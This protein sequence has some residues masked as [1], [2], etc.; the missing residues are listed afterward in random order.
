MC[1]K[2][3]RRRHRA[4]LLEPKRGQPRRL[5][6]SRQIGFADSQVAGY[7]VSQ[8]KGQFKLDGPAFGSRPTASP[9]RSPR[10]STR[11]P[12]L[13]QGPYE[14]RHLCEDPRQVGVQAAPS[15]TRQSFRRA[16][17]PGRRRAVTI[18]SAE[19]HRLEEIRAVPCAIQGGG[20]PRPSCS[21]WRRCSSTTRHESP[22]RL[23]IVD[24]YFLSRRSCRG[25]RRPSS[26][27]SSP[28]RS[29]SSSAWALP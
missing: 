16:A 12:W 19:G 24:S 4:V 26:S 2:P 13:R 8:S 18:D 1:K 3:T 17:A 5:E 9:S 21:C 25:S 15:P 28:W 7:I 11:R 6:R 29:A 22:L 27:R 20:R 23:G 14:R 10:S